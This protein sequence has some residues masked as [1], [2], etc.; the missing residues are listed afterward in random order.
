M[1]GR[2]T[3]RTAV[4]TLAERF[5]IDDAPSS[6]AASYN[7]APTQGVATVLVEDGKRKLERL[8]WGLIPSWA[9]NP[10]IGNKMI[11][12]RAETVA[13]KP[14]FRKAFKNHRCLVLADG[15][16]E[17][18]KTANGKQPYYIRMED[19]SPFAFAGLWESWQNG[20]EIRS[21]TIITTDANDVV[22]P[23]HNRM[24]VI[25]HPEDYQL[26][27]DPDFDEKEPLTTLLKPYPSE[28]MEAYPVSRRVN[29]PSNNEPSII[30]SVA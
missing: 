18:Q 21:A 5:E 3:L 16:Y 12:A 24:P 11:N 23:I 2:Y 14:S 17:W 13:E 22:A 27:L 10:S 29:S 26:W 8:H 9:D 20:S 28:A 19:G 6:V 1:C 7:V 30:E 15:F 4:D 25:L